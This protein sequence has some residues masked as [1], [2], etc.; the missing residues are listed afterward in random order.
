M[1]AHST[2]F[3]VWVLVWCGTCARASFY[4]CSVPALDTGACPGAISDAAI[5]AGFCAKA[6]KKDLKK[7]RGLEVTPQGDILVVERG[8]STANILLLHDDD[9]DQV[10]E[11]K[12]V[13]VEQAGL[14][15]GLAY[16]DGFIYASSST[17]VFRWP[18]TSGTRTPIAAAAET[19]VHSMNADGQGGAP[20]GHTTRTLVFD[21]P[22]R[23]YISIGSAGNVDSDSYRSRIR[24]FS[25]LSLPAGGI[26]FQAGEV[27][28][29]GLR[30]EVGLAFDGTG[31]LWGVENGA[32]NLNRADLG[33]DITNENPA[34]EL[35]RFPEA[36]KGKHW[37]Y[38]YCFSEYRLPLGTGQ[39]P[40]TVW[41][42]PS[43][44]RDGMHDDAWCRANTQRSVMAMQS[45]SAPL[46]IT[47]L[48]KRAPAKQAPGA[49]RPCSGMP[50][51]IVLFYPYIRSILPLY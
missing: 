1:W 25:M 38:P 51:L 44:M 29:D 47:F 30:N 28:A 32:D 2:L 24:R 20:L 13:L 6:F 45:H 43:F 10:A 34:E 41:A 48:D 9:G 26:A 31:V 11:G 7:P 36:E 17:T 27:F 16:R 14:N 12:T 49:S 39:G 23:L 5:A 3:V 40:G 21:A 46:G 33:G 50:V 42:W 37:G 35:N 22:G 8:T 18:F 19:V 4:Q 15:H